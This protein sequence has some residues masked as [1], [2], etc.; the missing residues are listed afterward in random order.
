MSEKFP[1]FPLIKVLGVNVINPQ[2]QPPPFNLNQHFV[3]AVDLERVLAEAPVVECPSGH[4]DYWYAPTLERSGNPTHT[5]RL[6]CVKP[7]VRDTAES[8]LR[9]IVRMID[10]C[11][12][13]QQ[14]LKRARRLLGEK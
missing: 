1:L 6:V 7:I 9:E 2:Y 3:R 4:Q 13:D 10:A 12:A 8:L 5:A 14:L 11:E